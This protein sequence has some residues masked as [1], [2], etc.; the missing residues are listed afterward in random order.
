[1]LLLTADGGA[2]LERGGGAAADAGLWGHRLHRPCPEGLRE[3]DPLP[4][5]GPR[6]SHPLTLKPPGAWTD[7]CCPSGRSSHRAR[8]SVAATGRGACVPRRPG[9]SPLW[10]A[11]SCPGCLGA[12]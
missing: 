1:M 4:A 8:P 11:L 7:S 9:R 2:G 6:G 12:L 5:Q 3:M 10:R